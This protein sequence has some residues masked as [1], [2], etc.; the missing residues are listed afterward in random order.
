VVQDYVP[1]MTSAYKLTALQHAPG[2]SHI[3]AV[4]IRR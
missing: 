2:S 1:T 4:I 3:C